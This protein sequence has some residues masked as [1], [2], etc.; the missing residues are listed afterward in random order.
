[1]CHFEKYKLILEEEYKTLCYRAKASYD[2]VFISSH[3]SCNYCRYQRYLAVCIP[4]LPRAACT[5]AHRGQGKVYNGIHSPSH[6]RWFLKP[7]LIRPKWGSRVLDQLDPFLVGR[8]FQE[9]E[10][11]V[12][13]WE[14]S[15]WSILVLQLLWVMAFIMISNE[16]G[17]R[18]NSSVFIFLFWEWMWMLTHYLWWIKNYVILGKVVRLSRRGGSLGEG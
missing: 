1:M 12:S 14:K 17:F 5:P 8:E 2:R 18:D 15:S 9:W 4:P 16:L 13:W 10:V 7:L 11:G 3:T 6:P